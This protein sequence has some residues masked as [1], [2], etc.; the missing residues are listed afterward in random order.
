MVSKVAQFLK[1]VAL[2][3]L[4]FGTVSLVNLATKKSGSKSFGIVV[5]VTYYTLFFGAILAILIL[6]HP[7]LSDLAKDY[8]DL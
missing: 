4:P 1:D 5:G 6:A 2:A 3:H 8:N 7:L